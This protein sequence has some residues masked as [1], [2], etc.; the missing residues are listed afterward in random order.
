MGPLEKGR[1]VRYM[2]RI[3]VRREI[4]WE[5]CQIR[6]LGRGWMG[7]QKNKVLE[8]IGTMTMREKRGMQ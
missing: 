2:T 5:R 4:Q 6:A 3:R 1:W 8:V 7:P